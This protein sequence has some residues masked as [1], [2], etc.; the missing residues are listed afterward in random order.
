[1]RALNGNVAFAQPE[2]APQPFVLAPPPYAADALEPY[3]DAETMMLHHD[4]HH[5]AYVSHL[6]IDAGE[7]PE[8]AAWPVEKTLTSLD[9][10]PEKVRMIVRNNLGGHVNHTMFWQVMGPP[11]SEPDGDVL[12]ALEGDFGGLEKPKAEF[13]ATGTRLFSSG[14]VFVTVAK[15]GGL[16]IETRA[17]QESPLMDGKHVLFGNDVWEHAYYLKYRNRRPDYLAAWWKVLNW[18]S[19]AER[20]ARAKDGTLVI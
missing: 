6:N 5:A 13:D 17:N 2:A 20:Y 19:V 3:I 11:G 1:M 18:K 9:E 7:A 12:A 10:V 4:K 16:A 15:D 14:W 8:F